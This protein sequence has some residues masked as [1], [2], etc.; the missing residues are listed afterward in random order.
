[1]SAGPHEALA[2]DISRP[3]LVESVGRICTDAT[4]STLSFATGARTGAG[5]APMRASTGGTKKKEMATPNV[6]VGS[7][8]A[9]FMIAYLMEWKEHK[10]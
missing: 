6:T 2:F 5:L 7:M 4:L 8:R 10:V 1:V 9:G 3:R